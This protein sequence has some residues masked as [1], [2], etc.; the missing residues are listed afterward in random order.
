M[1]KIIDKFEEVC[2]ENSRTVAFYYIDKN[3]VASKTFAELYNEVKKT[4]AYLSN[5]GVK[6]GD[7]LLAFASPSYNLIVY[8]L[9]TFRL[10]ASIM[11]V[12]IFAKQDSFKNFFNEYQPS[13]VLVSGRTMIF[14]PFFRYARRAKTTI[15]VDQ[16][17]PDATIDSTVIKNDVPALITATTGSSGKPKLFVRTHKDLYEQLELISNNL[18]RAA[19][20]EVVLTT[21][22]IYAFSNLLNG[23]TTVL[24]GINL[25]YKRAVA[26]S[27]KKLELFNKLKITTIMTSPDFCLRL[28]NLY[29]ELKYLYLGGAILNYSE[30]KKILDKYAEVRVWYI[31]GSTECA[32]ISGVYLKDYLKQLESAGK[33]LL[34][35]P[36]EGVNVRINDGHIMVNS[37]ALLRNEIDGHIDERYYDTNDIGEL[38]DGK[39]Y[40]I[41]KNGTE[42]LINDQKIFANEIEQRIILDQKTL[43]KCAVVQKDERIVVFVEGE[44]DMEGVKDLLLDDYNS[45]CEVVPMKLIP[46]DIKHHTKID[47]AKLNS[48]L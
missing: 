42:I 12:D 40:Y 33:C 1:S 22:Y 2:N 21:S 44:C 6:E 32:L 27:I 3:A 11:Y 41:G 31:Y 23:F 7:K 8:M 29:P 15:N 39:I 17:L 18:K 47:Y 46:R 28:P 48:R 37:K 26:G 16:K 14:R 45:K 34:G 19:K 43:R 13:F 38:V 5:I 20:D 25:S 30:T 35:E 24:P 4:E 9:A 36:C 10:G